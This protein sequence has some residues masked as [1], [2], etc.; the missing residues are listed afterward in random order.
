MAI[1][2][3]PLTRLEQY[4]NRIATGDGV[5]PNVPLTRIEQYLNRIATKDG[6]I[7]ETPLNRTEQYLNKIAT[8]EGSVPN[9]PLT[10]TE[11]YLAKIAGQESAVPEVPLSRMEQYLAEIAENGGGSEPVDVLP[12]EYQRVEWI[13]NTG[14]SYIAT[15][16]VM[17][18]NCTLKATFQRIS[19][20]TEG[21]V[22]N[23]QNYGNNKYGYE[24]GFFHSQKRVFSFAGNS[25]SLYY[26]ADNPV[27]DVESKLS[28]S[29]QIVIF[30]EDGVP[31]AQQN[32]T[33]NRNYYSNPI[34]LFMS[35]DRS[36][37]QFYGRIY[38]VTVEDSSAVLLLN[39][40][41]CYR[42]SDGVIGMY[43]TIST[44]F[45]TNAGS[46]TFLKGAD[47]T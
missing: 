38:S 33:V 45:Y 27:I 5:I 43:D 36:N 8:G 23:C 1:P 46:G 13:E 7:P 31:Q 30:A 17:P 28:P 15:D 35:F 22:V 47:V 26:T 39:L 21:T 41:P 6:A 44:A 18:Q 14:N 9:V 16:F 20:T 32:V 4:L 12:S 3:T 10:R 40:V 42:K 25:A 19:S 37:E 34:F 24:L 11:Q 2:E 29:T